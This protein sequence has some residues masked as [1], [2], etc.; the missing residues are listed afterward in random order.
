MKL[1]LYRV[2]AFTDR[3]PGGQAAEY[4]SGEIDVA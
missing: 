4:L 3:L 1:P 2:D